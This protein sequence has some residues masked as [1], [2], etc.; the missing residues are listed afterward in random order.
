MLFPLWLL[1]LPLCGIDVSYSGRCYC[2]LWLADVIV[3]VYVLLYFVADVVATMADGNA[4]FVGLMRV[5]WHTLFAKLADGI[6]YPG[7]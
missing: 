3:I 1:V 4:I 7:G 2:H 6:A 5:S